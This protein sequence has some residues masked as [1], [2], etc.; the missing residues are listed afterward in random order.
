M[1]DPVSIDPALKAAAAASEQALARGN[2]DA[3]DYALV[4]LLRSA[5]RDFAAAD[6]L[7][8]R[9]LALEPGNPATL[10]SL[11]IHYRR[12]GRNRDAVLACD[13]AIAAYPAYPDAW[14]ER[15]AILAAGGSNDAARARRR[16]SGRR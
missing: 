16:G 2:G 14:L 6:A 1:P 5:Q 7:F 9:A 12:Q 4:A 10:T 11:A 3:Y 15:G 8:S 13:Q